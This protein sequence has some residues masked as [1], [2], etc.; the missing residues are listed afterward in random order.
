MRRQIAIQFPYLATCG[1]AM[2]LS[3]A[4]FPAA[5]ADVLY[6]GRAFGACVK[7]VNPNPNVLKF[8]DTGNLPPQGGSLSAS[9][10]TILVGTGTLSSHTV[11][12]ST[13]GANQ[14]ASSSASQE[15]G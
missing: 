2:L 6:S 8:S 14:V 7:L 15:N 12:A 9:L 10:V 1:L 5:Y 4:A 13:S 11:T 3:F